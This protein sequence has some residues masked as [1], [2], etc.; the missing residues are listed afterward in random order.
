MTTGVPVSMV[1]S[2]NDVDID[3]P[4]GGTVQNIKENVHKFTCATFAFHEVKLESLILSFFFTTFGANL[5]RSV[6]SRSTKFLEGKISKV[7]EKHR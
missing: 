4:E 7:V 3:M 6:A 1:V 5:Q 2:V